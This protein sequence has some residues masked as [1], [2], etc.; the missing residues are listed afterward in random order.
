MIFKAAF[1]VEFPEDE[2]V[3]RVTAAYDQA[4]RLTEG[5]E[6]EEGYEQRIRVDRDVP[7]PPPYRT[8][9][10]RTGEVITVTPT[11]PVEYYV[12]VNH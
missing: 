12:R 4:C 8:F 9:D 5:G 1:G 3:R 10:E 7:A 2:A 6:P 11:E